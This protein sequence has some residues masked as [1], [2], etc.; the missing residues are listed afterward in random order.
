MITLMDMDRREAIKVF[1]AGALSAFGI[2]LPSPLLA[3]R[4]RRVS[5]EY[6]WSIEFHPGAGNITKGAVD[7]FNS[8]VSS[9]PTILNA[10][11]MGRRSRISAI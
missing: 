3:D 4:Q 6:T 9:D 1:G 7:Y 10:K 2:M 5:V 11:V 8:L